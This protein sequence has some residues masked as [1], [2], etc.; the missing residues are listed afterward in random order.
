MLQ[1]SQDPK[2]LYFGLSFPAKCGTT[3]WVAEEKTLFK[4]RFRNGSDPVELSLGYKFYPEDVKEEF[5][6]GLIAGATEIKIL[7]DQVM[8]IYSRL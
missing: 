3:L 5:R 7:Y 2:G 6:E 1:N 8:L 4:Q